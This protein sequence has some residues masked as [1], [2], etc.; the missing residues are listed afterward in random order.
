MVREVKDICGATP[1][2]YR[3]TEFTCDECE[4]RCDP[5]SCDVKDHLFSF[6]GSQ[7]CWECLQAEAGIEEVT[8]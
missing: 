5:N 1:T 2:M 4:C 7:L 6:N 3:H 8:E